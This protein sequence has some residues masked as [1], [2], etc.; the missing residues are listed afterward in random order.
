MKSEGDKDFK[1]IYY[2]WASFE[3][4]IKKQAAALLL[5]FKGKLRRDWL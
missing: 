4:L 1:H 2:K 3:T 5:K